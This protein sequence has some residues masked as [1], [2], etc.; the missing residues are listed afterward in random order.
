MKISDETEARKYVTSVLGESDAE[1]IPDVEHILLEIFADAISEANV[2]GREKW[3]VTCDAGKVRLQVGHVIICTLEGGRIW[4]ALDKGLLEG[5][6]KRPRFESTEDWHWDD[7]V[8]P[9]YSSIGSRNGYYKP[10]GQHEGI[11]PGLRRLHFE[12]IY[13]AANGQK[14]RSSTTERHS[15]GILKYLRYTL[16]R[17]VPDPLYSA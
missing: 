11:W 16:G 1:H 15:S 5:T 12:S 14:I 3:A 8:Y 7:S 9:E 17:Q 4:M 13:R 2:H 6:R 10:S